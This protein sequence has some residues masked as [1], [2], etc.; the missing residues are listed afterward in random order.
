MK[1]NMLMGKN[2]GKVNSNGL[3]DLNLKATSMITILKVKDNI[4]GQTEENIKVNG[5]QIKWKEKELLLGQM[6][7]YI[8]GHI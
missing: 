4:V 3:T 7:E 8:M 6:E 2:M 5:N 1:V